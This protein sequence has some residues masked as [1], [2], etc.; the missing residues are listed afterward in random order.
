MVRKV[1][2]EYVH[3]LHHQS[4]L[5]IQRECT[6]WLKGNPHL[7][8][9]IVLYLAQDT[10]LSVSDQI[11]KMAQKENVPN[12][13]VLIIQTIHEIQQTINDKSLDAAAKT[14]YERYLD[15]GDSDV[16]F[17]AKQFSAK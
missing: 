6:I 7:T 13:L 12:V 1:C 9:G 14:L 11:I 17:Y 15:N 10:V 16:S 3:Q 2:L 5:S 8:K 4:Q